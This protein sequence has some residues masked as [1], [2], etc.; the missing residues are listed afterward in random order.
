MKILI[1]LPIIL[2]LIIFIPQLSYAQEDNFIISAIVSSSIPGCEETTIGCFSPKE[3][4]IPEGK[5]ITFKNIDSAAHTFTSGVVENGLS[6]IFD[7]G[8]VMSGG[9]YQWTANVVGEIPYFCM[10]HPWAEGIIHVDNESQSSLTVTVEKGE[11]VA[12]VGKTILIKVIGAKQTV[13]FEIIASDGEIIETLSFGAS[14]E[15]EINLPW[16]IPKDTEPGTYIITAKDAFNSGQT[17]FTIPF[18]EKHIFIYQSLNATKLTNEDLDIFQSKITQWD[19]HIAQLLET[20]ENFHGK[21][22]KKVEYFQMKASIFEQLSNQLK[23]SLNDLNEGSLSQLRV[24]IESISY[25]EDKIIVNL[26]IGG[27]VGRVNF[28]IMDSDKNI[29]YNDDWKLPTKQIETDDFS[30]PGDLPLGVYTIKVLGNENIAHTTF[31]IKN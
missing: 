10:V 4:S 23:N 28:Y 15:G 22:P 25:N 24:G 19:T 8:L 30:L 26:Q 3:I 31:E 27:T 21:N 9:S 17:T 11:D 29:I 13:A 20:A 14:D 2:T 16:I 18:Y 12:G 1:L 7:S 6:G 5:I